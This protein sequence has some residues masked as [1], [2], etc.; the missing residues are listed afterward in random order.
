MLWLVQNGDQMILFTFCN[1]KVWILGSEATTLN[2]IASVYND[3][4][5]SKQALL[6]YYQVLLAQP[7]ARI[8][9]SFLS[10]R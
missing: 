7:A 4:G 1:F 2:N 9:T 6:L 10:R 8:Q 5:K 3:L